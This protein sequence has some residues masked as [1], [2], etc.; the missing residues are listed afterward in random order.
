M[1]PAEYRVLRLRAMG[2]TNYAVAREFGLSEQTIKN[3]LTS[4][5]QRLGVDSLVCALRV[6]GWLSVPSERPDV[7]GIVARCGRPAGHRGHHG[8]FRP[9]AP[10]VAA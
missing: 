9:V 2:W 7:C 1:T 3:Q 8:G 10:R 5:Y 6:L 4:S